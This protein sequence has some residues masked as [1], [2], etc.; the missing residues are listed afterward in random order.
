M[1]KHCA[2]ADFRF[3]TKNYADLDEKFSGAKTCQKQIGTFF[4]AEKNATC[5]YCAENQPFQY[6][7]T[8]LIQKV[9]LVPEF[10]VYIYTLLKLGMTRATKNKPGIHHAFQHSISFVG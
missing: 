7:S 5:I 3:W 2:D 1:P 9:D 8:T 4:Q 10:P 6:T